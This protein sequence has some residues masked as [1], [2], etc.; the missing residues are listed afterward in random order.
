MVDY[1][2]LVLSHPTWPGGVIGIVAGR[3]AERFGKPVAL[4]TTPNDDLA[5]GS[6]RS[7]PGVNLIAALTD[8]ASLFEGFGGHSGAAGFSMRPD[9]IPRLRSA[10]SQAV[11]A[12]TGAVLV[13]ALEIDA[14]VELPDLRLDLVAEIDRL[15]PFGPGNPPLV[16][17]AR[18]LRV[19]SHAIIGRG[20]EHSRIAVEDDQER[21][22]TVFWWQGADRLLPQGRFD[23]ALTLR[24]N[25]YRG[26]EEVQIEWLDA[27]QCEP[28]V[29]EVQ[30]A[31]TLA[32]VDYRTVE[33]PEA[34][35]RNL[36]EEDGV[37]IWAEAHELLGLEA[38]NRLELVPSA[39]LAVWTLPPGHRELQEAL[40]RSQPTEVLYFS[41]DPGLDDPEALLQ[42]L[43]GMVKYAL[44]ARG[45]RLN[46]E[47]VAAAM[48]QR[49]AATQAGLEWL[50]ATG[51]IRIVEKSPDCWQISLGPDT[52]NPLAAQNCMSRLG[53]LLA[54]TA[55]YRAYLRQAPVS[56]L[57]SR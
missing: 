15:A 5:R 14:Y 43:A 49:V 42:R 53:A 46:L 39:K 55:A 20:G 8:C 11:S 31:S 3:L 52:S 35:L 32:V 21:R 38:R 48:A 12:Q 36:F 22:K 56:A 41:Y 37:Q 10:L 51:K 24:A 47:A 19:V 57:G 4:I 26:V 33:N 28:S 25:D 6:A 7:S 13:P 18:N 2:A 27:R 23:L 34:I 40:D 50:E 29:V 17:A 30:R 45:G 54:E 9:L 16:F 44:Q 1:Q